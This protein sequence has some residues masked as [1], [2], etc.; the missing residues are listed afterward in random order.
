MEVPPSP[1]TALMRD[2]PAGNYGASPTKDDD[3]EEEEEEEEEGMSPEPVVTKH[4]PVIPKRTPARVERTPS[5]ERPASA[6]AADRRAKKLE[7]L[8]PSVSGPCTFTPRTDFGTNK[9][10]RSRVGSS[11]YGEWDELIIVCTCM[12][13]NASATKA[14]FELLEPVIWFAS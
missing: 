6:S 11:K 9:H 7:G 12:M 10:V 4:V 14:L 1:A 2:A 5:R 13:S 8:H 3:E